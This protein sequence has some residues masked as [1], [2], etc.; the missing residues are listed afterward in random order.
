MVMF[1]MQLNANQL[2]TYNKNFDKGIKLLPNMKA[3]IWLKDELFN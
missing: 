1:I 2:Y 3:L